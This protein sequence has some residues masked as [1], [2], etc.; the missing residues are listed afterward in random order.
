M[1]VVVRFVRLVCM[2]GYIVVYIHSHIMYTKGNS[3]K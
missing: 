3:I 1:F 2:H